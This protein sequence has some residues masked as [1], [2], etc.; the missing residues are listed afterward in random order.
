M[1]KDEDYVKMLRHVATHLPA[2][3]AIHNGDGISPKE[4]KKYIMEDFSSNMNDLLSW[5]YPYKRSIK[6]LEDE[7][8]KCKLAHE[9]L[10][11][12]LKRYIDVTPIY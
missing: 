9:N 7:L 12:T 5:A 1:N 11:G 3:W 8:H 6:E 4:M 10:K 2:Y